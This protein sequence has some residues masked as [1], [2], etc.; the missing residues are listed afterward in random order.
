MSDQNFHEI[1]LS[2]KQLAFVFMCAV[3]LAAVIFMLGVSVGRDVRAGAA[4]SAGTQAAPSDTAASAEP[5]P[6][7]TAPG[8]LS[9]TQALQP[10]PTA[11]T[12]PPPTASEP[13]PETTPAASSQTK[14]SPPPATPAAPPPSAAPPQKV[15]ASVSAEKPEKPEKTD[16]LPVSGGD[17]F[18]LQVT[19]VSTEPA[20]DS[21][22]KT[23][24]GKGFPAKVMVMGPD[25]APPRFKVQV[26]PYATRGDAQRAQTQLQKEGFSPFVLKR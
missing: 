25:T 9:A 16:A 6:T 14:S 19:S 3:V 10:R 1:Q 12:A 20:A 24:K 17:G 18:F 13:L 23:L 2:G 7:T 21:V 8:D 4:I 5:A 15:A 26:G 22:V 11:Q